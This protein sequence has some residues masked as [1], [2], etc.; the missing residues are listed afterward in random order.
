MSVRPILLVEDDPMDID[1]MLRADKV[2]EYDRE[3][4]LS[5]NADDGFGS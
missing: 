4:P 2:I 3:C 5:G 1:L